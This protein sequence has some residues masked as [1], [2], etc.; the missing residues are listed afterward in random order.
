MKIHSPSQVAA[1]LISVA[2]ALKVG[3]VKD[4]KDHQKLIVVVLVSIVLHLVSWAF[5]TAMGY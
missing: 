1:I 2:I 4:W 5:D 3:C